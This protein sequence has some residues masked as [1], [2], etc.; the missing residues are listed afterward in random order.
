MSSLLINSVEHLLRT[1]VHLFFM[2]EKTLSTY[3]VEDGTLRTKSIAGRRNCII[4][5]TVRDG[6]YISH[7]LL[8]CFAVVLHHTRSVTLDQWTAVAYEERSFDQWDKSDS[9]SSSPAVCQLIGH[10]TSERPVNHFPYVFIKTHVQFLRLFDSHKNTEQSAFLFS[11][12][13]NA[14]FY[15]RIRND[16]VFQGTVGNPTCSLL[17]VDS[18]N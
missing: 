12:I 1:S 17:Y 18:T 13:R 7:M 2:K 14:H 10:K 8:Q 15:V 16:S 4:V 6:V 9:V 11:S 5:V 3:P